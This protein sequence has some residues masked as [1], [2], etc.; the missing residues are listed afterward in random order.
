MRPVL[1]VLR[2]L[3]AAA[4]AILC[5]DGCL[6]HVK[7]EDSYYMKQQACVLKAKTLQESKACRAAVDAEYGV[8][9]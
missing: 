4:L 7:P 1:E 5:A 8:H 3:V 2:P 6:S 9:Q